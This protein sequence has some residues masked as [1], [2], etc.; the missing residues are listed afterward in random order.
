MGDFS[1]EQLDPD[2]APE[3]IHTKYMFRVY[4]IGNF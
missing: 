3:A 4:K 2:P 1:L